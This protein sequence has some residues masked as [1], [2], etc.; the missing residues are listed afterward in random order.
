MLERE[1]L[2]RERD[3]LERER[4]ERERKEREQLEAERIE[5]ERQERE[6]LERER[7]ERERIEQER[8]RLEKERLERERY[9][10][11]RRSSDRGYGSNSLKRPSGD[12]RGYADNKRSIRE[13]PRD[14]NRN[15]F[16]STSNNGDSRNA[17]PGSYL[18]D[19][20]Y[21]MAYQRKSGSTV[22][23]DHRADSRNEAKNDV[24]RRDSRGHEPVA[25]ARETEDIRRVVD[26]Y[27][28]RDRSPHRSVD[29]QKYREG[30]RD[31][32][33]S[34]NNWLDA[35]NPNAPKT[36]SDVLGRAGLTGILG[37][38]A[39]S[40]GNSRSFSPR[41]D[42]QSRSI[43]RDENLRQS[44]YKLDNR[45]NDRRLVREERRDF[46]QEEFRSDDRR[47]FRQDERRDIRQ[48]D[49]RDIRQD[50]RRDFRPDIRLD[51]RRDDRRDTRQDDRRDVRRDARYDDRSRDDQRVDDRR[52]TNSRE[53][54]REGDYRDNRTPLSRGNDRRD[55]RIDERREP[56]NDERRESRPETKPA[57]VD[58]GINRG[59][60]P[61]SSQSSDSVTDRRGLHPLAAELTSRP[62]TTVVPARV[63]PVAPNVFGRPVAT[64]G[65]AA[66]QAGYAAASQGITIHQV[67]TGIQLRDGRL[68][69]TRIAP[70][71]ANIQPFQ[72]RRF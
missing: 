25:K 43:F 39:E 20:V 64:A 3:R 58:R 4:L 41:R 53:Q 2:Q 44:V 37:S 27:S 54:R 45:I 8:L 7:L 65:G 52:N 57:L 70:P 33:Y 9:E 23:R 26:R 72:A 19:D 5:R 36:L 6:R 49:R 67:P 18:Q 34:R 13:D 28:S 71:G 48:D 62:L 11:E 69:F 21:D 38:Q 66:L 24:R 68:E 40:G 22:N 15:S 50:D 47:D 35:P 61:A 42:D 63:V 55:N 56:R 16:F 14:S 1:R 59:M 60:L 32:E 12:S 29:P 10:R 30:G 51:D 17:R 31:A 46:R